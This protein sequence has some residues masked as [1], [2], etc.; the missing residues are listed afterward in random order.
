MA[1]P[2]CQ[3]PVSQV[4]CMLHWQACHT[5]MQAQAPLAGST[6]MLWL[7]IMILP[8]SPCCTQIVR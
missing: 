7:S 4:K 1:K 6:I 2:F 3:N 8:A 5:D